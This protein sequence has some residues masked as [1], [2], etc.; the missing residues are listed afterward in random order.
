MAI[1]Y[2]GVPGTKRHKTYCSVC[3]KQLVV[4]QKKTTIKRGEPGFENTS[5]LAGIGLTVN[6][7]SQT[8]IDHV[9]YC[10]SCKRE[11]RC[12]DQDYI[13]FVQRKMGKTII[14]AEE[15]PDMAKEYKRCIRRKQLLTIGGVALLAVAVYL[16]TRFFR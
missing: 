6:V 12:E 9:Y 14:S 11:I 2:S 8:V 10:V 16:L 13:E 7:F 5:N 1:S 4:R 15:M 3:G